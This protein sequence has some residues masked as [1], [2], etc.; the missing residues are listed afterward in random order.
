MFRSVF[1]GFETFL[2]VPNSTSKTGVHIHDSIDSKRTMIVVVIALLPALLFGMYNV[3]YQHNLAIGANPGFWATFAF[4]LLAVLPKII[5]SYVVGLGIE[6][7]VAQWKKEEI[8][9]AIAVLKHG[10]CPKVTVLHCNTEYPTPYEDANLTAMADLRQLTGCEVGFSD[11]T[12]GIACDIAAAALGATV[13]EKHFTLDKTMEGPDHKAS[14]EPHELKEMVDS[15]RIVEKAL[16]DGKKQVSASE[17]KN[18][19]I[20]R[21]SIVAAMPIQKGEIFTA[22]NLTTKRPGDGISPM[23]WYDVL[24]CCAKRDFAE[25]EKIE[26]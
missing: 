6:F 19:P 7:A 23:K 25:D 11:H 2:F 20:A 22:E 21:K 17:G 15:I 18:K 1:D 24:G 16:G 14:L 26:L 5:V 9:E 8:Q 13:I 3:G 12:L 4:G 10:G